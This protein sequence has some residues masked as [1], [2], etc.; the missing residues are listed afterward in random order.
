MKS[1]FYKKKITK[2]L[3]KNCSNKKCLDTKE[4]K[5]AKQINYTFLKKNLVKNF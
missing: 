3:I 4:K 2:E 5:T 1:T